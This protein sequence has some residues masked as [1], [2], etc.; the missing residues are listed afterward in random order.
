MRRSDI[1]LLASLA[2]IGLKLTACCQP[3]QSSRSLVRPNAGAEANNRERRLSAEKARSRRE[4]SARANRL[5]RACRRLGD[6]LER[7]RTC[8]PCK[9]Q[10]TPLALELAFAETR[11]AMHTSGYTNRH[12]LVIALKRRIAVMKRYMTIHR[13]NGQR[14]DHCRLL[15]GLMAE[16]YRAERDLAGKS[17]NY[18]K[19]HPTIRQLTQRIKLLKTA[20]STARNKCKPRRP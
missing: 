10:L 18:L 16:A 15:N 7:R 19:R 17:T 12:P 6:T 5:V 1:L 13:A 11:L 4:D 9:D 3:C 20:V 2:T 14:V 8:C